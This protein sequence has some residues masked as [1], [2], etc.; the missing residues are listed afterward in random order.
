MKIEAIK[1]D[2]EFWKK[3]METK[4]KTFYFDCLLPEIID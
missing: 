3:Y 2:N 1:I 4:L